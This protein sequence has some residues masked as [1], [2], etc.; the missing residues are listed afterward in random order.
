MNREWRDT[1]TE[2]TRTAAAAAAKSADQESAPFDP[3]RAHRKRSSTETAADSLVRTVRLFVLNQRSHIL[4]LV[5]VL[6]TTI[7]S[8]RIYFN[9]YYLPGLLDRNS[10]LQTTSREVRRP[11]GID[12]ECLAYQDRRLVKSYDHV[13]FATIGE[14]RD[15]V[16]APAVQDI[17]PVKIDHGIR[18]LQDRIKRH[19]SDKKLES[20]MAL[21]LA[22]NMLRE[23]KHEKAA[24]I[25]RYA[26]SLDPQNSDALASY[27]EFL[28]F[29]QKDVVKAE[30]M[31]TLALGIE[32]THDK[33]SA[34]HK[35]AMPLVA[36]IDRE[37]LDKLDRLLK[38]FYEIPST[39]S[40]LKRA[41]REAY[42]LHIYHS[43]AIEGNTLNLQQTRHIVENRMAVGG[44]SVLEHQEV[45]GLDAAMRYLNETLL[46]RRMGEMTISD[47]LEIHR[48]VLGFSDPIESGKLRKHQVFVGNFVPP[49]PEHV[50]SLMNEFIE[51]LN[52]KD[53]IT[54]A[55]P[56]Q[57]AALAHYKFVYIHPFYDGNGRTGRLLMNLLLMRA[58]YPPVI[59][60]KQERLEYY[61]H[62]EKANQGDVK[63]FIRFIARCTQR[64]L[65]EYIRLCGD[66]N[67]IDFEHH[68]VGLWDEH[69]VDNE[70][71][72]SALT[73]D[74]DEPDDD[75]V[76]AGDPDLN[77]K[78]VDSGT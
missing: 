66:A 51:W 6:L 26:L 59:I 48:R 27:G 14:D 22:V 73:R 24:K 34:N 71:D 8:N 17:G 76:I 64:T 2:M 29:H 31:Y 78:I 55:H 65:R 53:L 1:A 44:K 74:Y 13:A 7:V 49:A 57:I 21:K 46:Y 12:R 72:L 45:L 60:R 42:F 5:L 20:Q 41:K 68:E 15:V 58:G 36:K 63:P 3:K 23:G 32:P 77:F 19:K 28:E 47:L 39:S 67:G 25:Y 56:I 38:Q 54:M 62:L 37:M 43:N 33:A 50:E 18:K 40:A 9:M 52:S 16:V 35:R 30:H 4:T 10:Q 69:D 70:S 75:K 11:P 61:E